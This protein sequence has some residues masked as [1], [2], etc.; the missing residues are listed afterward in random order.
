MSC[1]DTAGCQSRFISPLCPG[2]GDRPASRAVAPRLA[3]LHR[4]AVGSSSV[5]SGAVQRHICLAEIN[6]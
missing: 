6:M 3:L 4:G 2:A 5:R 1:K